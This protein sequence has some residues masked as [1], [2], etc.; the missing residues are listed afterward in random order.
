MIPLRNLCGHSVLSFLLQF[1]SRTL[2]LFFEDQCPLTFPFMRHL[3]TI[4]VLRLTC[5]HHTVSF[6][7]VWSFLSF[8]RSC[9][10]G[11][12]K[13]KVMY[14]CI[15]FIGAI[16]RYHEFSGYKKEP[17]VVQM[18]MKLLYGLHKVNL[19]MQKPPTYLNV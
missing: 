12:Y 18:S 9:L 19:K 8:I 17:I 16:L 10:T 6:L 1:A 14:I 5:V 3:L 15:G 2:F 13:I 4:L 7:F 11:E